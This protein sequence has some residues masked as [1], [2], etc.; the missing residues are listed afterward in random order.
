MAGGTIKRNLT[1]VSWAS[2]VEKQPFEPI[3]AA[4]SLAKLDPDD[5]VLKHNDQQTAVDHI[6]VGTE[7]KATELQLLALHDAD[8]APSEWGVGAGASPV[9]LGKDR[10]TAFFT[11]VLLWSDNVAAF[12]AH[13]NAPGL[14]RLADYLRIQ[15]GKRVVFR[16]LYEQG[17]KEELADLDHY[18]SFE[19]GIHD[20]H[21]KSEMGTGMVGSLLPQ[22]AQNVPSLRVSMSMGRRSPRDA[23][24][25]TEVA[26][27]VIAMSDVA[28]QFFDRMVISGPSKTKKQPNGKPKQVSVNLLSQRLLASSEIARQSDASNLPDRIATFDALRQ[29]RKRLDADGKINAAQEARIF[30]DKKG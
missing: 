20:P 19:Y 2:A 3:P 22:I 13:S 4:E 27:D 8:N 11:H 29:A 1:F 14:G 24:L 18:R 30:L 26:D 6:V 9:K 25:P 10:F 28:E 15:T 5:V 17:L 7:T 23:Y 21:K 16:A 12:D